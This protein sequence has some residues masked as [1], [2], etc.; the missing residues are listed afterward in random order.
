MA[1]SIEIEIHGRKVTFPRNDMTDEQWA[2]F[3]K[4]AATVEAKSVADK[5]KE[6]L[7]SADA[8]R[9]GFVKAEPGPDKEKSEKDKSRGVKAFVEHGVISEALKATGA[10]NT[11]DIPSAEQ[12]RY[13]AGQP[14]PMTPEET[15]SV[16]GGQLDSLKRVVAPQP[17]FMVPGG[18]TAA[19]PMPDVPGPSLP[20]SIPTMASRAVGE[21]IDPIAKGVVAPVAEA[22]GRTP[23]G[24]T[25]MGP[26]NAI[27][28]TSVPG[29]PAPAPSSS[30]ASMSAAV[31]LPGAPTMPPDQTGELAARGQQSLKDQVA[32]A[33]DVAEAQTEFN[34]RAAKI[35]QDSINAQEA[36]AAAQQKRDDEIQTNVDKRVA[37]MDAAEKILRDP[38]KTPDPERYWQSH[39]K[40]LFAIGVGLLAANNRDI[41]GV[42][43]SV[44]QAIKNDID[45]QEAE[46][47]APKNAAKATIS[48]NQDVIKML[49][50]AQ[51]DAFER[52]KFWEASS[53]RLYADKIDQMANE[54]AGRINVANATAMAA[55]LR[56]EAD[57]ADQDRYVHTRANQINEYEAKEK[58]GA[59]QVKLAIKVGGGT[60]GKGGKI[61]PAEEANKM[62][63]FEAGFNLLNQLQ[64]SYKN[65]YG[66]QG[67]VGGVPGSLVEK[68]AAKVPGTDA[69]KYNALRDQALR[70]IGLNIDQSVLQKHDV[71]QWEDLL[72]KAGD[73]N[74]MLKLKILKQ[75]VKESRE[76]MLNGFTAA[77]Y[78]TGGFKPL[79]GDQAP[80]PSEKPVE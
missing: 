20:P 40:V 23:E 18:Q 39:S 14:S 2:E 60:G 8:V 67:G 65:L 11:P 33:G 7:D 5:S 73:T 62:S 59:E 71:E 49:R 77:G 47:N 25:A 15:G 56:A 22:W 45:A 13:P 44:N 17:A 64:S 80:L 79:E 1:D 51:A 53:K 78:N 61:L 29:K 70:T 55:K 68:G 31:R 38:T 72:P 19:G 37:A 57:K 42:L 75:V 63:K 48:A 54:N 30:S 46:F 34:N 35:Q 26:P 3:K 43:G 10:D 12:R 21:I 16:F 27:P 41:S 4:S 6:T 32:A 36:R 76:T 28:P 58:A 74:A 9:S 24:R 50:G 69:T 66:A 52:N